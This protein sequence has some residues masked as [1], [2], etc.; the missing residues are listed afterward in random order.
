VGEAPERPR[1]LCAAPAYNEGERIARVVREVPREW[2]DAV[3]VVDDGSTDGTA[4]YARGAGATVLE[5]GRNRGVGAAIRTAIGY[6]RSNGFD[7]VVITSG[8]GKTPGEQ[9]PSLVQPILDGGAD[10][11]QG[12]RYLEGGRLEGAPWH[13]RLGT[14]GYSAL[15]SLFLGRRVTDASSGFRAFRLDL[16][17]APRFRLD[18]AWL[19][20]YELEPYLLFQAVRAGVRYR[21]APVRIVYPR[22]AD[23]LPYTKMRPFSGWWRIFRPVV[24][25][26]LGLKR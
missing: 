24:F 5:H 25:L 23:G 11:V 12:S 14:W 10:F 21:E 13:R 22:K 6:G 9:I 15:F 26:R 19:D 8:G 7:I 20:S 3:V 2:V 1:V 4:A 18:Q 16:L 17:D